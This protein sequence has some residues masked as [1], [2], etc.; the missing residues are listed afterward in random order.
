[1]GAMMSYQW[2]PNLW[3]DGIERWRH[4][5]TQTWVTGRLSV[6]R[7]S[8]EHMFDR[9][10]RA[11]TGP[12]GCD[13]ARRQG[14]ATCTG[15]HGRTMSSN[16]RPPASSAGVSQRMSRHP[17]RDTTP[18]LMLRRALHARGLRY[19]T[20][21]PV[22]GLRRRTIDI[23][24]TRRRLAVFVD[25]CFWHGCGDHRSIPAA[26]RDWWSTK[27]AATIARDTETERVLAEQGW[28]VLRI[29]EH[30]PVSVAVDLVVR[31]LRG[32]T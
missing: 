5:R 30:E 21:L 8:V 6:G 24:F 14:C 20:H 18:E 3:R 25:G 11:L 12:K 9:A 7:A 17:R 4:A 19:R 31:A 15:R 16:Y 26:N 29:W 2:L 13:G 23:A 1:M 10:S 22:P 32:S 28:S 27:I